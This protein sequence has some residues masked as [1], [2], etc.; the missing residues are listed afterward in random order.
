MGIP[1]NM[2]LP[3]HGLIW[4]T[5]PMKIVKKYDE[6]SRQVAKRKVVIIYDT[7]WHSTE[8]MAK[9][10]LDGLIESGV[11]AKLLDLAV[12]HRSDVVTEVQDAKAIVLGSATLNNGML[13]RMADMLHYMKGLRPQ[14]KLGASFGSYGWSGEAVKLMNKTLEE[15]KAKLI[16][17]GLK[18]QY[19]PTHEDLKKCVQLGRDVAEAVKAE[20]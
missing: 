18:I 13:P 11:D 20:V 2:I 9:A 16:H 5:D 6:W 15:M 1:I 8:M 14:N 17:P 12:N 19:V 10:I 4:R 3:D 7:M